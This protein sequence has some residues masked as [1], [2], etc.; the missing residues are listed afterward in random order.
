MTLKYR[1]RVNKVQWVG[2]ITTRSVI[3][4]EAIFK[5]SKRPV[6]VYQSDHRKRL[7]NRSLKCNCIYTYIIHVSINSFIKIEH[8]SVINILWYCI[9][10]TPDNGKKIFV[11]GTQS[12]FFFVKIIILRVLS[13]S[14]FI[15]NKQTPL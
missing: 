3:T 11:F 10:K 14:F 2:F 6:T 4:N 9:L 7:T 1:P 8:D 12:E 5:R 15:N 13:Q